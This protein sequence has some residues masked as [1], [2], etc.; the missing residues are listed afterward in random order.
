MDTTYPENKYA[1]AFLRKREFANEVRCSLKHVHNLIMRGELRA[2]RIG[3]AIRIPRSELE[4]L[5]EGG[6][7]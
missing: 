7:K 1:P 6:A 5:L 3:R 4:R 2:I